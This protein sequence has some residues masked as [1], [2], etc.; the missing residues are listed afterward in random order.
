VD[1]PK[2]HGRGGQS[3]VRFARLRTEKRHN[4]MR[5]VAELATQHFIENDRPNVKGA[6]VRAPCLPA[7]VGAYTLHTPMTCR[8]GAGG[9]GRVE[10][11]AG[12][13]R[14]HG[15]PP[16]LGY[17]QVSGHVVRRRERLQPS[18]CTGSG[19]LS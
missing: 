15:P 17:C 2:K 14:A 6:C 7:S 19:R 3:S 8:L 10:E 13:V 9:G 12:H 1:L 16:G 5:K 11:R 18:H 4:Y